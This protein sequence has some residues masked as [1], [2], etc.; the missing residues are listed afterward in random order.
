[1]RS[2][3]G[4]G[5]GEAAMHGG[6]I[7]VEIRAV[8]HR[9]LDVRTRVPREGA[10]L[11]SLLEHLARTKL[12]RGRFDV[13][14]RLG[15][16]LAAAAVLDRDRAKAVFSEL[17]ALRDELAPGQDVPFW[18]IAQVPEVFVSPLTREEHA[19]RAA[20]TTAFDRAV[21]ALDEMRAAEGE[22]LARDL[23]TRLDHTA[24]L[25]SEIRT[26][27]A[28]LVEGQ[29]KKLA[30]RAKQIRGSLDFSLDPA[31]LEQ[32]IVL[33]ADRIDV[34][35]E[36]TRLESHIAQF[37][38][39]LSNGS[40]V[41][42]KLDFLLQEMTRETNTIGAKTPDAAVAHLVVELKA[43]ITRMREQVQNVE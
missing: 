21:S 11:Q 30:D 16:N 41:G 23:A 40:S 17:Q 43:E 31:R 24:E 20:L 28:G 9:Y 6:K 33:Y 8:N 3:T 15:G 5:A 26:K 7:T 35:E 37:R 36:L 42:R 14:L 4:F 25:A 19:V 29:R 18:M 1:M 39:L 2:M 10:D 22:S 27:S 32:E 13:T 34:A 12:A 38:S